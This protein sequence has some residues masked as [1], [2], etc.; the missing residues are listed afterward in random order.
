MLADLRGGGEH[1]APFRPGV[2]A[3]CRPLEPCG[4][5]SNPGGGADSGRPRDHSN[6]GTTPMSK[7]APVRIVSLAP[8]PTPI[9]PKLVYVRSVPLKSA[10]V[11]SHPENRAP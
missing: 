5:G 9:V 6:A 4:P 10:P 11:R 8:A 7:R 3:A 1:T 2:T